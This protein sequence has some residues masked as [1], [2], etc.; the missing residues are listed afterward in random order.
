MDSINMSFGET[1]TLIVVI[2]IALIGVLRF[3]FKLDLNEFLKSR[4]LRHRR[5]AQHSCSHMDL[6]QQGD[7]IAV[8]SWFVSPVVQLIGF[9]VPVGPLG[10]LSLQRMRKERK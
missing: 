4:K 9:V 10:M 3:G 8:Q 6:E 5:L 1:I 7:D 2:A